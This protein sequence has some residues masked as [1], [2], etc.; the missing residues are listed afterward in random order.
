MDSRRRRGRAGPALSALVLAASVGACL[1]GPSVAD[2]AGRRAA[3]PPVARAHLDGVWTNASYTRL[4]RPKSLHALVLSP[5]EARAYEATLA[6]HHGVPENPS[7]TVGQIDSEFGDSGDGLARIHGEIR[8]S[9][10]TDPADGRVPYSDEGKRR[11]RFGE[12]DRDDNPEDLDAADRCLFSNGGAPPQMSTMETNLFQIVQTPTRVAFVSEK[13]H[14]VRLIEIAPRHRPIETVSWTGNSVGHWE[15]ATLVVDTRGFRDPLVDRFFVSYSSSA[16]VEE[17][18][19]RTSAEEI[20]YTF[21]VHDP[22]MFTRDWSGEEV[23]KAT[24][25]RIC[26]FACHEGNYSLRNIL[27][28]ARVRDGAGPPRSVAAPSTPAA[29]NS[30]SARP[31]KATS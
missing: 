15:G 5:D 29:A 8:S 14:A 23:F 18:F 22:A 6:A 3:F 27:A 19:T 25:G 20:I 21:K 7:D 2:A 12:P 10:I 16:V 9:W 24:A 30:P 13:N 4:Q 28:G 31:A 11:M 17:R 26:E 1:T